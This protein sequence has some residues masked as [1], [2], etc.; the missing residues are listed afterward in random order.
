MAIDQTGATMT[1][2]IN[3]KPNVPKAP[4][5]SALKAPIEKTSEPQ[6]TKENTNLQSINKESSLREQFPEATETEI[7]LAE[8]FKT[9]TAEDR[10]AIIFSFNGK[11]RN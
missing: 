3:K 2:M 11:I 1:G 8:R 9:L 5:M 7:I 6:V 4:D 10:A